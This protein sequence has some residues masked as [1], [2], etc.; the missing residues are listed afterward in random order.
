MMHMESVGLFVT[1]VV[2]G[3]LLVS[4]WLVNLTLT[5]ILLLVF[6]WLVVGL[7][8]LTVIAE[9]VIRFYQTFKKG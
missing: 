9:M 7:I 1:W 8:L 4:N 3:A 6:L 2:L 5:A